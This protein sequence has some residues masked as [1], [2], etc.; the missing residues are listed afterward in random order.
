MKWTKEKLLKTKALGQIIDTIELQ[1]YE[2]LIALSH[3]RASHE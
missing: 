2:L 3:F 1:N